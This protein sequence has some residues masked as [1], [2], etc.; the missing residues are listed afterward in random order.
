[1]C[2]KR[3]LIPQKCLSVLTLRINGHRKNV[4]TQSSNDLSFLS[5]YCYEFFKD[6]ANPV[7]ICFTLTS[8]GFTGELGKISVFLLQM[9]PCMASAS[10]GCVWKAVG[11]SSIRTKTMFLEMA[12]RIFSFGKP[13]GTK[14]AIFKDFQIQMG[15]SHLY[16]TCG[17]KSCKFG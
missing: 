1:M 9:V 4:S 17:S 15:P 16:G 6:Y 3:S 2:S 12:W 13:C 8:V 5:F 10:P 11:S 14:G 7:F